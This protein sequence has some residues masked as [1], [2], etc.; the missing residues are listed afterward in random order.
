[1]FLDRLLPKLGLQ[2]LRIRGKEIL[3]ISAGACI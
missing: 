1:M 2:S 3:L